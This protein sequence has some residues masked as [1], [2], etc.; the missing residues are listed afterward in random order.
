MCSKKECKYIG[1]NI[2][3]VSLRE[4]YRQLVSCEKCCFKKEVDKHKDQTYLN[5]RLQYVQNY[6][7]NPSAFI[8]M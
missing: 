6:H 8:N 1:K 5:V 2:T 3:K 7:S 4:S